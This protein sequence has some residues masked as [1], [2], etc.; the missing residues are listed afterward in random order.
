MRP[1]TI[2][3]HGPHFMT[4]NNLL[5]LILDLLFVKPTC[6]FLDDD[7]GWVGMAVGS[8]PATAGVCALKIILQHTRTNRQ[9]QNQYHT[10]HNTFPNILHTY[11][12]KREDATQRYT[13]NTAHPPTMGLWSAFSKLLY[14]VGMASYDCLNCAGCVC[15]TDLTRVPLPLFSPYLPAH[16]DWRRAWSSGDAYIRVPR[17][18]GALFGCM[19]SRT[20]AHAPACCCKWGG[21]RASGGRALL[22]PRPTP[23]TQPSTT[24]NPTHT[25]RSSTCRASLGCPTLT[26]GSCR[27]AT[28]LRPR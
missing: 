7:G 27:S 13:K 23:N 21:G 12:I 15:T 5:P 4:K 8:A 24:N 6:F 3:G 20:R 22:P 28:A 19:Q 25:K 11:L 16:A 10:I 17:E 1:F 18:A 9:I 14:G 2:E 26:S